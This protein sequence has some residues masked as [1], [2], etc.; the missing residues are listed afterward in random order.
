[1]VDE[2]SNDV[3]QKIFIAGNEPS[4]VPGDYTFLRP[5]FS[6]IRNFR[7]GSISGGYSIVKA[8][9]LVNEHGFPVLWLA[10][11]VQKVSPLSANPELE[12]LISLFS[13]LLT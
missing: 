7:N 11:Q 5:W 4:G 9:I 2:I 10:P 13:N 3:E 1:M 12:S 8:T 6:T